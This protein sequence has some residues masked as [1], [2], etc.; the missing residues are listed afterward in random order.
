MVMMLSRY[1]YWLQ[2]VAHFPQI[3]PVV[4][5]QPTKKKASRGVCV[6]FALNRSFYSSTSVDPVSVPILHPRDTNSV[7]TDCETEKNQ[8]NRK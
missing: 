2:P 8:N 4:T 1:W 6:V 7:V 5:K 3:H